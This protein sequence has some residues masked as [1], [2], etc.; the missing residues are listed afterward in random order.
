MLKRLSGGQQLGELVSTARNTN[1]NTGSVAESAR[2]WY[3]MTSVFITSIWPQSQGAHTTWISSTHR[4]Q[5]PRSCCPR[6]AS[7]WKYTLPSIKRELKTRPIYDCRCDELRLKPKDDESTCL[8]YT[9]LLEDLVYCE[10]MN[11]K[12]VWNF[13]LSSLSEA[14]LLF[15]EEVK[16]PHN[17][18]EYRNP[19]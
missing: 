14:I 10:S 17:K 6:H 12:G 9:G 16:T 13:L 15:N 19:N 5:T 18:G 11:L 2:A 8:T 1:E 7:G 4:C 3:F